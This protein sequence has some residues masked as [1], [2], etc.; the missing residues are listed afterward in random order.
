VTLTIATTSTNSVPSPT[1]SSVAREGTL[2][3]TIILSVLVPLVTIIGVAIIWR[4]A[5]GRRRTLQSPNGRWGSQS[6]RWV[7]KISRLWPAKKSD[8]EL[9][10][11]IPYNEGEAEDGQRPGPDQFYVSTRST[12]QRS[13]FRAASNP[14][15]RPPRPVS[16]TGSL[17]DVIQAGSPDSYSGRLTSENGD[18]VLLG[19]SS[20]SRTGIFPQQSRAASIL[21]EENPQAYDGTRRVFYETALHRN[22]PFE[23]L[24]R[25]S[26]RL[27]RYEDAEQERSLTPEPL[28]IV[29]NIDSCTTIGDLLKVSRGETTRRAFTEPVNPTDHMPQ[30]AMESLEQDLMDELNSIGDGPNIDEETR[31]RRQELTLKYLEG[32]A[33]MS[34]LPVYRASS[35]YSRDEW[36]SPIAS[37]GESSAA[38]MHPEAA[39]RDNEESKGKGKDKAV[40][41]TGVEGGWI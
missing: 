9:S 4:I 1:L 10:G 28:R 32:V 24:A 34:P 7:A 6:R 37:Q 23:R 25:P 18:D 22:L 2:K 29:K 8:H 20:T 12:P 40:N 38:A 11:K 14:P 3:S 17:M 21:A 13:P 27:D 39:S 35:V 15:L 26:L 33:P 41:Q 31:R 19:N 36:G 5:S 16:L 30:D